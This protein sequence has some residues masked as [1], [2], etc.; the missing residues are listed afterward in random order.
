M[1]NL[2]LLLGLFGSKNCFKGTASQER[3]T[4]GLGD[5]GESRPSGAI[6]AAENLAPQIQSIRQWSVLKI[7]RA[8]L[9]FPTA[10]LNLS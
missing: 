4:S 2:R 9:F 3:F 6:L 10:K 5:R 7:S 1:L 8:P